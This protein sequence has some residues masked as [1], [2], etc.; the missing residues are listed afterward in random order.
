[1]KQPGLGPRCVLCS[2]AHPALGFGAW[3]RL[4]SLQGRTGSLR[5]LPLTG[6]R[7]VTVESIQGGFRA[8][9][10]LQARWRC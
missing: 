1:M 8:V 3:A 5:C 7:T 2:Q 4:G 6:R 9:A 10:G